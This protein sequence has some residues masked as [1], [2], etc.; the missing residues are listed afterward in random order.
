MKR[1]AT[2]KGK[3][4]LPHRP[5]PLSA[6]VPTGAGAQPRVNVQYIDRPDCA[7]IFADSI[8]A[9]SFDGQTLRIEFAVTRIDETKTDKPLTGRRYPACRLVLPP[10]AAVDLMQKMQQVAQA[11]VQAGYL[12]TQPRTPSAGGEPKTPN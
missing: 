7:E 9:L 2:P 3:F 10:V 8:S 1:S 5:H 12:K 6:D 11:L 4:R